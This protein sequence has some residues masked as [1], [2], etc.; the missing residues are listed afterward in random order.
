M[1]YLRAK[2]DL[3]CQKEPVDK[4]Q[5][6]TTKEGGDINLLRNYYQDPKKY[7]FE[8]QEFIRLTFLEVLHED[9]P[10]GLIPYARVC[11]R[12]IFSCEVFIAASGGLTSTQA[13]IVNRWHEHLWQ[14][15]LSGERQVKPDLII[16]LKV[17]P[18]T[19]LERVRKRNREGEERVTLPYLTCLDDEYQ[20]WLQSMQIQG[21]VIDMVD[22]E[23]SPEV[24][25]Q[26]IEELI[27]SFESRTMNKEYI[28]SARPEQQETPR[29]V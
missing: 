16:F 12:C 28:S 24:V 14:E 11:E 17:Q 18:K 9:P 23:R 4:W 1:D 26:D 15:Q 25:A 6:L 3:F 5:C 13:A 27:R 2:P 7:A 29:Q 19:C 8:L 10:I 20:K 22:G 21:V